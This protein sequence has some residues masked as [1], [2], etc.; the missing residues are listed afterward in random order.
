[1]DP[2][3]VRDNGGHSM[4]EGAV[5]ID[6][7]KR[8]VGRVP[9]APRGREPGIECTRAAEDSTM[10][11]LLRR[12][13]MASLRPSVGRPPDRGY[14]R[15]IEPPVDRA[16]DSTRG[17]PCEPRPV[18]PAAADEGGHERWSTSENGRDIQKK[19]PVVGLEP[20]T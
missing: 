14:P 10:T 7:E 20:T 2:P 15:R 6:T 17:V 16:F 3:G 18:R 5:E 8:V 9:A 1:M 12:T 11:T 13:V 4:A 19:E